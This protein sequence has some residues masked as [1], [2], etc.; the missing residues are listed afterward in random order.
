MLEVNPD[1]RITAPEIHEHPWVKSDKVTLLS[2]DE[3]VEMI[4]GMRKSR[5]E[6][7]K[8]IGTSRGG[9]IDT[10]EEGSTGYIQ[11]EFLGYTITKVSDKLQDFYYDNRE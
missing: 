8:Q 2:K 6:K 10:G 3:V 9:F 1:K 7:L 5:T 4:Q 11:P